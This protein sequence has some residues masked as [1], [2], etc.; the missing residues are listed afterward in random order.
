MN[1]SIST[2]VLLG[3]SALIV[4]Y[5]LSSFH[6][7]FNRQSIHE[8]VTTATTK[9][10]PS[11]NATDVA[12]N[13]INLNEQITESV[14]AATENADNEQTG[15][16]HNLEELVN[17]PEVIEEEAASE[18]VGTPGDMIREKP[19]LQNALPPIPQA[20]PLPQG[21][22]IVTAPTAESFS[23]TGSS[24][25]QFPAPITNIPP[26]S[27][28]NINSASSAFP[29]PILPSTNHSNTGNQGS[30]SFPAPR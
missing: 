30:N 11:T 25:N 21:S 15:T 24:N 14:T 20:P 27:D 10:E 18:I 3:I 19:H 9:S 12:Q 23:Q 6:K 26:I 8:Q 16:T 22:P 1:K 13:I 7:V 4:L 17:S 29:A 2:L 28:A 5:I